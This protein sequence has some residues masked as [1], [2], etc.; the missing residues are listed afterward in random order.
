MGSR[1]FVHLHNH[2][3]T[4]M[5]DGA[6]RV[7]DLLVE[8]IRMGMPAL[9]IT[10]HGN[11]FSAYA[12][13]S[14][15]RKLGIN[16]IIGME[17]YVSPGSRHDRNKVPLF[18]GS[19]P[20]MYTHMTLLAE[21]TVGMHNLFRLASLASL[22]GFYYKP[23]ID[24]ELLAQYHEGIIATTGCPGGEVPRLLQA[25]R[26]DAACQAASDFRDIFGAEN[27]F[28]E[29]MDHG[30]DIERSTRAD[31]I[32]LAT[33]LRLPYLAT[34]DSHYVHPENARAHD[35]LLCVQTGKTMS[36]PDRFR[37]E[38]GPEYYL[39]SPE[40]M[41]ALFDDEFP[42]ACNN[43]LAIAERVN[44]EFIEGR[45]DLMPRFAVPAREGVAE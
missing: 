8:C 23:R 6:A 44:V 41:R 27:Y 43:T 28:C 37:F 32:R 24:K 45:R 14:K 9:A 10:D 31:T 4:S 17:A 2:A 35:V 34:N 16:P 7:D 30:I 22:E 13:W 19:E 3:D 25:G 33:R 29:L 20:E 15:A 26:F 42:E 40:Q 36:N 11:M 21:T 5:L 39:K 12:L 18:G 38:G 1:S